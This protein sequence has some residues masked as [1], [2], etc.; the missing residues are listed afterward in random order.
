MRR[1]VV[2]PVLVVVAACHGR[3]SRESNADGGWATPF[4]ELADARADE[5]DNGFDGIAIAP[6]G[7]AGEPA[8]GATET[9][10]LTPEQVQSVVRAHLGGVRACFD[11][12]VR[13]NPSLTGGVTIR[14]VIAPDGSVQSSSIAGNTTRS[15]RVAS[16]VQRQVGAWHFPA[17][18]S[19]TNVSYPFVYVGSR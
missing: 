8:A 3:R 1:G 13:D 4:A 15:A 19:T 17:T 5:R 10:G 9:G 12:E 6:M 7:D 11:V 16:C 18:D 2:L 14:W